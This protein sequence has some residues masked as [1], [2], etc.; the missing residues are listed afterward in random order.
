[1]LKV[2]KGYVTYKCALLQRGVLFDGDPQELAHLIESGVVKV[3]CGEPEDNGGGQ[4]GTDGGGSI[5]GDPISLEAFQ[6]LKAA[7]QKERLAKLGVEPAK[8]EEGRIEQYRELI[9][10]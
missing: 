10:G 7:E 8:N 4:T 9:G 3:V 5:A 6:D 2:V 1:M